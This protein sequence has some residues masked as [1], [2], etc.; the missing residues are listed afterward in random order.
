[1][2]DEVISLLVIE[3]ED[4]DV[5]RIKSTLRSFHNRIVIKDVVS[6]GGDALDSMRKNIDGY[7]VVIMDYQISGGLY[8]EALITEIKKMNPVVQII[9]V[10]KKTVQRADLS[11]AKQLLESGAYWFCTKYPGDIE[12]YIYQPNDFALNIMNAYARKKLEVEYKLSQKRLEGKLRDMHDAYPIIGESSAIK[13]LVESIEQYSAT[14]VIILLTGETGTGKELAARN[15]HLKS[16]RKYESFVAINCGAIPVDL[17]ESELF[18]YESGAFTGA[19]GKK[20]GLFEQANE[21]TI[22]LD[23]IGELPITAQV[24]LL[25]V[26]Q[27]G[28]SDESGRMKKYRVNVRV[29]AATNHDLKRAVKEKR[30]REDLYYR[31][32]VISIQLPALREY[33]E[34]IPVLVNHLMQICSTD[35]GM[36]PP[37]ISS[38]AMKV[39]MNYPWPGNVREL[40]NVVQRLLLIQEQDVGEEKVMQALGLAE[41][42]DASDSIVSMQIN[43]EKILPLREIERKFREKYIKFVRSISP[44]DVVAAKKLGLAPLYLPLAF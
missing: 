40:K 11:F 37:T 42:S 15:I 36:A 14:D 41:S 32:N 21:G 3:D 12:E 25:R 34:D 1:M 2:M 17:I 30:F 16:N 20:P 22:F 23:E 26:L 29:I 24:K 5:R 6:S 9:V 19:K 18:G 27:D 4:Y 31:I 28:E 43:K 39:L 33:S 7:D 35:I 13:S 8:G 38:E 44:T 10:T